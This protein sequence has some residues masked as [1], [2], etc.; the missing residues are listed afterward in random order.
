LV[1]HDVTAELA[2]SVQGLHPLKAWCR[3]PE[4]GRP[5]GNETVSDF[6]LFQGLGAGSSHSLQKGGWC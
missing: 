1:Y 3:N 4:A 6:L 5:P 2:R